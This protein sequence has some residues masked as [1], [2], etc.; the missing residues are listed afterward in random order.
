MECP[1][2][3]GT[4]LRPMLREGAETV[5]P[6]CGQPKPP[7][8]ADYYQCVACGQEYEAKPNEKGEPV[9]RHKAQVPPPLRGFGVGV[10]ARVPATEPPV[11]APT[12]PKPP[13]A[14]E[15]PKPPA[16]PSTEPGPKKPKE[17]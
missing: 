8:A 2:H 4:E 9:E 13:K 6:T 11:G 5:C 3:K 12:P 14:P 15:A 7:E 1:K 17:E 10:G 16:E